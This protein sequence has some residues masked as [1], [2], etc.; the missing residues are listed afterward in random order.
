MPTASL[1]F[2]IYVFGAVG[3]G[4]TC[5]SPQFPQFKEFTVIKTKFIIYDAKMVFHTVSLEAVD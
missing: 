1:V 3:G 5:F 2:L 4:S